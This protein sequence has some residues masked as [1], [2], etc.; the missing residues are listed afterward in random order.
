MPRIAAVKGEA[1]LVNL[2]SGSGRRTR[3]S[4]AREN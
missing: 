2:S 3:S 4:V 1:I